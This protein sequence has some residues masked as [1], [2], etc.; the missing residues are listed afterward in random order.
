MLIFK[1]FEGNGESNF[2][3]TDMRRYRYRFATD[4]RRHR[5]TAYS[6]QTYASR[7]KNAVGDDVDGSGL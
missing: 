4:R 5:T 3:P 2:I 1:G 7:G 6:A